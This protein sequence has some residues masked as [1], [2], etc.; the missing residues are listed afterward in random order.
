[1]TRTHADD[2]DLP[3]GLLHGEVT[4]SIIGAFYRVYDFF[5]YGYQEAGYRRSL[6]I[7]LRSMGLRVEE[8]VPFDMVFEGV[9][10]ARYRADVIV[11]GKVI[12]E[13]KAGLTLDPAAA[14]Q[15]LNYLKLTRL[16]VGL[17][18]H[19]GPRP[20]VKRLISTRYRLQDITPK[21]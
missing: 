10:V 6:C 4:H 7:A 21:R 19:F 14:S 11:E 8:E 20:A 9:V 15:L 12:V 16:E 18:L 5:G 17:I 3:L 1:M 13:A 2:A